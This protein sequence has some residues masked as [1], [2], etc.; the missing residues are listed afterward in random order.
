LPKISGAHRKIHEI[1]EFHLGQVENHLLDSA[2]PSKKTIETSCGSV[3]IVSLEREFLL[4]L[5]AKAEEQKKCVA[6]TSPL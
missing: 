4:I 3:V 1:F 5:V 6:V 2:N